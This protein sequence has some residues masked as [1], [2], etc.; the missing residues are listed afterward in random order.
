MLIV[1]TQLMKFTNQYILFFLSI[2][3]YNLK[4]SIGLT[5]TLLEKNNLKFND[6]CYVMLIVYFFY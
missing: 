6:N 4:L 3:N 2:K 5:L 1:N